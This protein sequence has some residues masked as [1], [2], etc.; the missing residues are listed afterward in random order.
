MY[1]ILHWKISSAPGTF[2]SLAALICWY[3]VKPNLT[4]PLFY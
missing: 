3:L 1:N 4:D 2:G